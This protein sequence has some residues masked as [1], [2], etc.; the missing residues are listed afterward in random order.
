MCAG[1]I[2]IIRIRLMVTIPF[3]V[4][5]LSRASV[6]Y[7]ERC[8]GFSF[9]LIE[10]APSGDERSFREVNIHLARCASTRLRKTAVRGAFKTDNP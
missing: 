9:N 1:L 10:S 2:G 5:R 7:N 6:V 8:D 4:R 3:L